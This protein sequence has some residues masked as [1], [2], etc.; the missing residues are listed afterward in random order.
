M[1]RKGFHSLRAIGSPSGAEPEP[2]ATLETPRSPPTS[3][4]EPIPF[5]KSGGAERDRTSI[6]QDVG[7][8]YFPLWICYNGNTKVEVI[9]SLN[10]GEVNFQWKRFAMSRRQ[11]TDS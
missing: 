2:E 8:F 5:L 6:C 3:T 7:L 10:E 11:K 9:R 1:V 4:L